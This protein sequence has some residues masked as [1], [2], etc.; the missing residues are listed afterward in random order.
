MPNISKHEFNKM[1]TEIEVLQQSLR[2]TRDRKHVLE[3]QVS[4]FD[5]ILCKILLAA[6]GLHLTSPVYGSV[7]VGSSYDSGGPHRCVPYTPE[8][9]QQLEL[10]GYREQTVELAERLAAVRAIAEFAKEHKA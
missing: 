8:E 6:N 2:E 7:N 3:A 10:K 9:L 5:E 4:N 1:Q